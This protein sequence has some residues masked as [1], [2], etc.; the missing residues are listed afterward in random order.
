M[1]WLI[2]SLGY[3]WATPTTLL[4]LACFLLPMWLLRQLKPLRWREGVWEW[5]ISPNSRF[6]RRY[7]MR[8]WSAT[9][10]GYCVF[11]SPGSE[12]SPSTAVHE[13][14]H[15]WQVLWWGPLYGYRRNP[16]EVDAYAWEARHAK[17]L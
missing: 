11:Y 10:L 17:P 9:T 14:R 5:R 4:G 16:F 6:W 3:L 12:T 15:V 7:S 2:R 13:R 8:G 1:R